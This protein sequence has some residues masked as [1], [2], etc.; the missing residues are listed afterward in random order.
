MQ[1][2]PSFAICLARRERRP[3]FRAG[4]RGRRPD[5]YPY[6]PT[7]LDLE[8]IRDALENAAEKLDE[9]LA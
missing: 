5:L 1:V 2:K 7:Q 3:S 6:H 9:D 8:A 4:R